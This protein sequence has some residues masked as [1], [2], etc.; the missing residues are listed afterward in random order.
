MDG[1]VPPVTFELGRALLI[2]GAVSVDSLAQALFIVVTRGMPLPRALLEV[3]A[4]GDRRLSEELARAEAPVLRHVRPVPE[5]MSQLPDGICLRLAAVPVRKD[6]M[7]GTVD[8][9]VLDASDKHAAHEIGY[10]L[11]SPVRV[12]RASL[13]ALRDAL[14]LYPGGVRSLAPPMGAPPPSSAPNAATLIWGTPAVHAEDGAAGNAPI[15][16]SRRA[17]SLRVTGA[18][19]DDDARAGDP[20]VL[21]Q[22]KVPRGMGPPS[23]APEPHA[24]GVPP[25]RRESDPVF[26]LR[27]PSIAAAPPRSSMGPAPASAA[28]SPPPP[29]HAA[30]ARFR[31]SSGP[32][33]PAFPLRAPLQPR[34][35]TAP[36]APIPP[37]AD[38]GTFLSGLKGAQDRDAVVGLVLLGVRAVARKAGVLVARKDAVVGWACTPELGDEAAFK[39]ISI[40]LATPSLLTTVLAGG[41]YLGPLLGAVAT[42]LLRVMKSTTE[43]VAIAAVRVSGRPALVIVADELG[44]TLIGTQRI[45]E[46]ARAA[47]EA[48]EHI[49]RSKRA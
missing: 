43:D 33:P 46:L 37:F 7:T 8:V 34:V 18:W 14:E 12:V 16:L 17:A 19:E 41:V 40:S 35:P 15:P 24:H 5:L 23:H 48:L 25:V 39:G 49:L 38:A 28:P 4:I 31:P 11:H 42:P 30:R 6:A 13:E 45:E 22:Q 47:G 32:P 21:K 26:E 3:G 36:N 9:A 20:F 27:R 29:P 44:D 10:H 2:S 1:R